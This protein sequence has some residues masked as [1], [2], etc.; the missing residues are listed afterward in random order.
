MQMC[1]DFRGQAASQRLWGKKLIKKAVF[2]AIATPFLVTALAA[3]SI[4]SLNVLPWSPGYENDG[5]YWVGL[6]EGYINGDA[7]DPFYMYCVDF[8]GTISAPTE[9]NVHL[10][11]LN[12]NLF[13][14]DTMGLT[15]AQ[16]QIQYL[17]GQDFGS[18]P[19]GNSVQD[20]DIQ[21]DI[22]NFTGGTF[23]PDTNMVN[24]LSAAEFERAQLAVSDPGFFDNAYL[25]DVTV[26]GPGQQAFMPVSVPLD[27]PAGAATPEPG[28]FFLFSAGLLMYFVRRSRCRVSTTTR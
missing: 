28:T 5:S 9:Y 7:S 14:G 18:T 13:T 1:P 6:T 21:Q 20:S 23:T 15:L 4:F 27:L 10:V 2:A 11:S 26:P 22:W 25:I 8:L 17:L 3:G 19:S 24:L 12:P 16:L